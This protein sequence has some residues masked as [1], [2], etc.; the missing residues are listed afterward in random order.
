MPMKKIP[1]PDGTD[2]HIDDL[3]EHLDYAV[4]F[5]ADGDNDGTTSVAIGWIPRPG[6][7]AADLPSG[8][9]LIP[10]NGIFKFPDAHPSVPKVPPKKKTFA[11]Q[12]SVQQP[13]NEGELQVTQGQV[14][15]VGKVKADVT[16]TFD[17]T[18]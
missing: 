7:N 14:T 6:T 16:W 3:K 10:P 17:V 4:K 13:G 1:V 5:V 18:K 9:A 15:W 2:G 11:L 12:I 8:L